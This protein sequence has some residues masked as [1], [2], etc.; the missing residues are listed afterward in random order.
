MKAILFA[1]TDWYLYNFRLDTARYL[2]EQGWDV[3]LMS[4]PGNYSDRFAAE[5]FRFIPFDFSRKGINPFLELTTIRRLRQVYEK[6]R[7]DLVHHF[8]IKCV[9]YGSFAAKQSGIKAIVN[10]ITGLGY[11]FTSKNFSARMIQ[12]VVSLLYRRALA[13]TQVIF[14]N[15]DDAILFGQSGFTRDAEDHVILGT[16]IDTDLFRPVPPPDSVVL[17]I[18][19]AR[20]LWDKGVGEFVRAAEIIHRKG[21]PARFALVGKKDDGNP[22]SI[23]YEQMTQWQKEQNVEWWGWQENIIPV[24]S[25][26]DIVCLPSYR[27]GLPKI[28]IEASACSRP[29]VATDVPGC[30][31]VVADGVTGLLVPVRNAD[32]LADALEKLIHDRDLRLKLGEA[33]RE[34]AIELFSNE[35]VNRET[36]IVYQKALQSDGS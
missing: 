6:E 13:G 3:V 36:A 31:E 14:E 25:M 4:P 26:A 23:S 20:L 34:R 9:I 18:L 7:P 19:P 12:K 17:T 10:A 32:A 2:K 15:P 27:E 29:I 35:R 11:V 33:G 16:G 5:G 28:L 21:I 8:T 22:S 30:R 24:L 1:N